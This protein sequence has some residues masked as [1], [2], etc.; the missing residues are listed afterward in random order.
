[1]K[2][3]PKAFIYQQSKFVLKVAFK[4]KEMAKMY[5][6]NEWNENKK[7][8]FNKIAQDVI[9]TS[10]HNSINTSCCVDTTKIT[11][12]YSDDIKTS[13]CIDTM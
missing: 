11:T 8:S 5:K 7:F 6:R 4:I 13:C 12:P 10:N 2:W 1:M 3:L 9:N